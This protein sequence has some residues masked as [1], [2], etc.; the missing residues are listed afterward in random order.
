MMSLGII[1]SMTIFGMQ[2]LLIDKTMGFAFG[3]PDEYAGFGVIAMALIFMGFLIIKS[4]AM[5]LEITEQII[6][7][8]GE[9]GAAKKVQALAQIIA[10]ITFELITWGSGKIVT[11]AAQYIERVRAILEKYRK[12][13]QQVQKVQ[14]KVQNLAGRK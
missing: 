12:I 3:N 11:T 2:K 5:A 10:G 1:V 14:Q 9:A 13:K 6:G 8:A 7:Y 4:C